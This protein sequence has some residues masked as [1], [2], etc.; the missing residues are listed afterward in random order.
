MPTTTTTVRKDHTDWRCNTLL[1]PESRTYCGRV[2]NM[3]DTNCRECVTERNVGSDAMDAEREPI[4][5]MRKKDKDGVET[6]EYKEASNK[7][8]SCG[9]STT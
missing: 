8:T 3:H 9:N 2:N 6:W 5:I 1:E 4:G 7:E